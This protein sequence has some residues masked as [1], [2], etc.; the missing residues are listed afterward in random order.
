MDADS[1]VQRLAIADRRGP[2]VLMPDHDVRRSV[3]NFAHKVAASG[4]LAIYRVFLA[5]LV[6]S[7]GRGS[8]EVIAAPAPISTVTTAIAEVSA[9]SLAWKEKLST[10]VR[11]LAVYVK[12]PVAG[13]VS[14]R[15]PIVGPAT[16]EKVSVSPSASVASRFPEVGMLG[17]AWKAKL[18]ATGA[19]FAP[20]LPLPS[21]LSS[22][23]APTKWR[24][25]SPLLHLTTVLPVSSRLTASTPSFQHRF[26]AS[27]PATLVD[28]D[29][30]QMAKCVLS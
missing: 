26:T 19:L 1:R 15:V 3:G 29:Y 30:D 5:L 11:A 20:P 10:P 12:A 27:V 25:F 7:T 2:D 6:A 13:S 16:M 4:R 28:V 9:P 22:P 21:P 17:A 8:V 18:W 24:P 23:V 14:W